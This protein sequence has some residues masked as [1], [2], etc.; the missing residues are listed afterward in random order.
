MK[1]ALEERYPTCAKWDCDVAAHLEADHIEDFSLVQET[2]F[3]NLVHWCPH[4]HDLKTYDRWR[5]VSREDG[6]WDLV[7]PDGPDPPDDDAF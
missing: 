4:H 2:R 1:V 3:E 7:P 5:P 6:Q